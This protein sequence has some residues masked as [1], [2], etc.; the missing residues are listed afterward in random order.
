MS[1]N[2]AIMY[3]MAG[4]V[5]LGGLDHL[6]GNHFG[7]GNKFEEGFMLL[8]TSALSMAGIICLA[9]FIASFLGPAISPLYQFFGA[10]PSMFASVLAL[11]MGGYPL[12]MELAKNA[13]VGAYSGIIVASM[14]GC[15]MVFVIPVGL[16]MIEKE[17]QPYFAKGLMIG[18]ATMP[19]GTVL[20]G[21]VA[22]LSFPLIVLNNIP[23]LLLSILLIVGLYK[24]PGKMVSGFVIFGTVIKK[25]TIVGL[26]LSAFT[27]LTGIEVIKGMGALEDAMKTVVNI[28]IVLLGSLPIAYL[29]QRL[30]EKPLRAIGRRLGMNSTSIAGIL[31]SLVSTLPVFMMIKDMNPRGKIVCVS[32]FVAS[33]AVFGAHLGFTASMEPSLVPALIVAKLTGAISA[34]LTALFFTKKQRN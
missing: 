19:V 8:G 25:I 4:G 16:S 31:I 14:L 10:D 11:D 13:A 23:I 1:V 2:D 7:L 27:S 30:L 17:D 24:V 33:G 26:M 12:A 34:I 32:F 15:T 3:I 22:R 18:L 20:G 5:L 9:P 28:C 29:L 6:F 21:M